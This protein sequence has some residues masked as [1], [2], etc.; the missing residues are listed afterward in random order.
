MQLFGSTTTHDDPRATQL[1]VCGKCKQ[2][3]VVCYHVTL[4]SMNGLPAGRTYQHKCNAC[5]RTFTTISL[6]RLMRDLM[7]AMIITPIG[8][9]ATPLMLLGWYERSF[10]A[11][12]GGDIGIL[13]VMALFAIGGLAWLVTLAI[14]TYRLFENPPAPPQGR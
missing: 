9:I 4:H 5:Q 6:W 8:L 2:P 12:S 10:T 11:V 14:R 3:A 13:V 1:R 7:V